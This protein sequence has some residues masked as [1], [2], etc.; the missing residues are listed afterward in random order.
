MPR[1]DVKG[2]HP[3]HTIPCH[4]VVEETE[5]GAGLRFI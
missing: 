4:D 2:K 1:G 3:G 5:E